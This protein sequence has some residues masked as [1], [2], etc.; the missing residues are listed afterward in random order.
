[1]LVGVL[2][3]V[4]ALG[5]GACNGRD[6]D[7]VL[8]ER[9]A[10]SDASARSRLLECLDDHAVALLAPSGEVGFGV[11]TVVGDEI[12]AIAPVGLLT[13]TDAVTAR[14]FD[15][16]ADGGDS[17]SDTADDHRVGLAAVTP[18]GVALWGPLPDD[19]NVRALAVA[20]GTLERADDVVVAVASSEFAGP[21]RTAEGD[22]WPED[23]D[24]TLDVADATVKRLAGGTVRLTGVDG[25]VDGEVT[26]IAIYD[27]A[28]RLVGFGDG[29]DAFEVSEDELR[30][31]V[32]ATPPAGGRRTV[33]W[34]TPELATEGTF[35]L[36]SAARSER[37]ISP[38]G[39]SKSGRWSVRLV[40]LSCDDGVEA[41]IVETPVADTILTDPGRGFAVS[42]GY[43]AVAQEQARRR[44]ELLQ[45]LG[46][47]EDPMPGADSDL[48]EQFD[49]GRGAIES[50]EV[51]AVSFDDDSDVELPLAIVSNGPCSGRWVSTMPLY[52]SEP[53]APTALRMGT[54]R[55]LPGCPAVATLE[56]DE[57]ETVRV[58]MDAHV[59]AGTFDVVPVDEADNWDAHVDPVI[60]PLSWMMFGGAAALSWESDLEQLAEFAAE[61]P[62]ATP[63]EVF[64]N[65]ADGLSSE[66]PGPV[67]VTATSD[68]GYAVVAAGLGCV[69]ELG[70]MAG[71]TS[72]V[73]IRVESVEAD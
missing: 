15:T 52:V 58:D 63:M 20:P 25:G 64:M 69:Y 72:V 2:A 57:G 38:D 37:L 43:P 3:V 59:V 46:T 61:N 18:G 17:R 62:D 68:A 1:M 39:A 70:L 48:A 13:R 9:C 55:V 60:G 33:P 8:A 4:V 7:G 36:T 5:A 65:A 71:P 44:A 50:D 34:E 24:G 6:R 54:N 40:D 42:K 27:E 53:R 29:T 73:E 45:P 35:E 30:A 41:F 66:T 47:S 32:D 67:T 31:A 23:T 21:T 11:A 28:L 12:Y 14:R 49:A 26:N 51:G 56:L 22:R 19:M 16:V 10:S